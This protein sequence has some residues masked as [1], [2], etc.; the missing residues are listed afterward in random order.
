MGLA[1][2]PIPFI[3]VFVTLKTANNF[4][5]L[6]VVRICDTKLQNRKERRKESLVAL[7]NFQMFKK[8]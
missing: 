2:F 3:D 4:L 5:S 8:K 7:K 1:I 6:Q